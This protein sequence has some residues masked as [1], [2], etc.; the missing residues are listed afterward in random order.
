MN[1]WILAACGFRCVPF[2]ALGLVL[3]ANLGCWAPP[4]PTSAQLGRGAI[5]MFPGVEGGQWSMKYAYE[6]IRQ[7]GIERAIY[8]W[9]WERAGGTLVNLT[10]Y[11]DNRRKAAETA[12]DVIAYR[13]LHPEAPIDLVGYS[14]GAGIAVFVAEALPEDIHLRSIVLCHPALSP[15]YDLTPALQRVDVSL[16]NFYSGADWL[17]LGAGTSTFGTMDRD[18][19]AS[20]G[21]LGFDPNRAVKDPNLRSLLVQRHWDISTQ[22]FVHYGGHFPILS[23][24]WNQTTVAPHLR[25]NEPP[26]AQTSP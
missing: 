24:A 15:Q 12:E 17:I 3:V 22:G 4:K 7:A 1:R 21:M 16:V 13:A 8:V 10:E 19:G 5:W 11:D 18:Y 26:D 6:G 2:L 23:Q 20:A 9:D 14:G 25:L